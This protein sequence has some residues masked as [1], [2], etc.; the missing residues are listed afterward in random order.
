VN[1]KASLADHQHI[2]F[3][4]GVCNLCNVSVDFLI[5]HDKHHV[6]F[7]APLQG[8]TAQQML[9]SEAREFDSFIYW[10]NG[11]TLLESTA[12]IRVVADLGFWWKWALIFFIIPPFLR[13]P[14]YRWIAR[15]RYS[16]F[17]KKSICRLPSESEKQ[18]FLP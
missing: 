1:S 6:L 13:N 9:S 5:R 16:W 10:R 4:D 3:F 15:N 12:A 2:V 14:I 8:E 17:G 7:F 18:K 11:R